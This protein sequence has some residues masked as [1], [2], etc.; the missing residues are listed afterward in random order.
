LAGFQALLARWSGQEDLAVGAP[1]AGRTRVELEGL[2]GLFVNTLV[3]RGDLSGDPTPRTLV[4][5]ARERFLAAEAHQDLPFEKLVEELRPERNLARPVLFQVL[6]V[7]QNAPRPPLAL[8]GLAVT[9]EPVDTG[10][11]KFEIQLTLEEV[12][13]GLAGTLDVNRDLFD[14]PTAD[15]LVR[16]YAAL[17]AQAGTEAGARIGDLA[18][19]SAAEAQQLR[20]WNATAVER[21]AADTLPALFAVQV[22]RTPERIAVRCAGEELT[23]RQLDERASRLAGRLRRLGVGPDVVVGVCL[24]RSLDLVVALYGIHRAGGAYLP[25]DP[26]HPTERLHRMLAE[27]GAPVVLTQSVWQDR[28]A[29]ATVVSLDAERASLEQESAA[30]PPPAVRG[31]HLAYVI[32]TS[33]ST[34]APKGAM[35]THAAIANRILW[36]QEAYRLGADD[37]VLQKTPYTFDVSVWEFFWPLVVGA[38]LVVARPDGHRDPAYL[39]RTLIEEEITVLHF[40]PSMLQVFLGEPGVERATGVRQVMAS[41]EALPAD[42]ARRFHAL[43]PGAR[44]HNLY[45]P[46]EAAV[47]VTAWTCAPGAGEPSVPIG[48]PIANLEIRLLDRL[49]RPVPVGAPGELCIGG[50]GLARGYLAQP[51]LTADRFVPD[52][53]AA[54]PGDRLYRTGDLARWRPDGRLDYL[55]RLDHQVKIRGMRIEPGEIEAA[56][57]AFPGV[58]EAVVLAREDRLGDRR[59]VAYLVGE[60]DLRLDALRLALRESLP[61]PM[62]PSSYV[63]LEKLPVTANGKLDRRALPPPPDA[64]AAQVVLPRTEAEELIAAAWREALGLAAVG[65][66]DSFFD[67]GGHSLLVVQVH[68]LLAPRFPALTLVDLFRH[69]TISALAGSLSRETVD[70]ISLE[71]TRERAEDRSDRTRRQREL[72]RQVRGRG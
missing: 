61:E 42:L 49:A 2:I 14:T 66:E 33:G 51:A 69:P 44:L 40:V 67:L 12:D 17:L 11:A 31:D 46:T 50:V 6:F 29:A 63:V 25:L 32:F 35:N 15:R 38:R 65:V 7:L 71:E 55:G 58:R 21:P 57:A 48:R 36:M 30:G 24:E 18:L 62:V 23:Y 1:V 13:G 68:R 20:E 28:F 52:P 34:G 70:Q 22:A 39:V 3:L 41:G 54:A 5:R 37:R 4:Q 26:A 27:S 53:L 10:T 8:P 9:T 45:G 60:A 19:L 56:L 43:L 64:P 47:D 72:R 16:H 59:L